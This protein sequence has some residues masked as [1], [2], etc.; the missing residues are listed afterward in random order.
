MT[1]QPEDISGLAAAQAGTW[2]TAA[3]QRIAAGNTPGNLDGL[4]TRH[5]L[6]GTAVAG[7]DWNVSPLSPKW[8]GDN[9]DRLGQAPALAA[10]GYGL[11]WPAPACQGDARSALA[12]GLPRLMA[13]DLFTDP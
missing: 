8:L 7:L 2:L 11:A 4:F 12:D 5:L 9:R 6:A 10:L 3:A 1:G 13:R